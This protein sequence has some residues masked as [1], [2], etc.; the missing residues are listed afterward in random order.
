MNLKSKLQ[1]INLL[2]L[3]L[4]LIKENLFKFEVNSLSL[5]NK[6]LLGYKPDLKNLAL[7]SKMPMIRSKDWLERV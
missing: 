7:D 1:K 3:N 4:K 6:N 2:E 5:K